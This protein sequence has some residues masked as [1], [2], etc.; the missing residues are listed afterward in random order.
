ML[1]NGSKSGKKNQ[2]CRSNQVSRSYTDNAARFIAA[3]SY[4]AKYG[5]R[6]MRRY[7]QRN[8]EDVIAEHIVSDIYGKISNVSVS[9]KSGALNVECN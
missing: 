3:E 8:I 2:T 6:N 1:P 5:A 9:V 4:S 7:I